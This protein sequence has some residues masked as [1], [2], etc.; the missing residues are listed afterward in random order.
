M[1]I[2]LQLLTPQKLNNRTADPV[3]GL[4]VETKIHR[5]SDPLYKTVCSNAC[6]GFP[7][8]DRK[9]P[10]MRNPGAEADFIF[11]EKILQISG[12]VQVQTGIV[13]GPT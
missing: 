7:T 9:S 12:P 10:P 2:H 13:Q 4:P 5:C 1:K 11:I 8:T 6:S 3:P